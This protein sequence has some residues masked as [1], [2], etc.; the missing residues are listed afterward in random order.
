MLGIMFTEDEEMKTWLLNTGD[1]ILAMREPDGK[2]GL[3][4]EIFLDDNY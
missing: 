2:F 1:A 4:N 3:E